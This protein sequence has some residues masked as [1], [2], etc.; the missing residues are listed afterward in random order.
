MLRILSISV[1]A[2]LLG[3]NIGVA[4]A[5]SRNA[6][7]GSAAGSDDL[8]VSTAGLWG[9]TLGV[10]SCDQWRRYV[11][12]LF[13]RADRYH[14]GYIDEKQF[15]IIKYASP[16]FAKAD[17]GYFDDNGDGRVTKSEFVDKPSEFFLRF[18]KRHD[19]RVTPDEMSQASP[20]T[21]GKPKTG[22]HGGAGGP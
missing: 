9:G 6:T 4:Y 17:F 1:L 19:C 13:N 8:I 20:A 14:R 21:Q 3:A 18:D 11:T 12:D 16:I 22:R 15:K 10:Y 7:S 2:L 5:Q